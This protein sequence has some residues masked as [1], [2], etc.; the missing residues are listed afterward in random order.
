M[1]NTRTNVTTGKPKVGGA[2]YKAPIGTTLPT[3]T[4]TA[5]A[6]DFTCLGYISEDG[7]S[8]DNS[9]SSE[10]IKA[11][12]GDVVLA[13][14]TE[15][16]DDFSLTLIEA[17]NPDVLK[18]VY[19]DDKVT[20]TLD[21]GIAVKVSAEEMDAASYVIEMVMTGGVA[22]RVVIPSAKVSSISEVTYDDTSAVGYQVTLTAE[23]DSGG[24]SHYEYIKKA[25]TTTE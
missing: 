17:L 23:A 14:Q 6:A 15:R 4:S 12:G 19:G 9:I 8:N 18:V 21:T 16:N 24:Y 13:T 25:S 3:D 2:V 20:G 5:L 10:K 7:V 22:K 11:W 1:A